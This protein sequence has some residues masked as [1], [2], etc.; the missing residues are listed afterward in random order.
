MPEDS[1]RH[2]SEQRRS[3]FL[4]FLKTYWGETLIVIGLILAVFLLFEQMNIRD[5]LLGWVVATGHLGLDLGARFINSL[6]TFGARLGLSELIAIPLLIGVVFLLIWRIRWRLRN[7]PA[8]VD[9]HCPR[10]GGELQRVHRNAIDRAI[11][12]FVSVRRYRCA[13]RDC[14]WAGRRVSPSGGRG[15]AKPAPQ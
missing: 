7:T 10:C 11:S 13:N 1:Q 3:P 15:R 14:G 9:T 6:Q 12:V 2:R 8:L 5:T 4:L